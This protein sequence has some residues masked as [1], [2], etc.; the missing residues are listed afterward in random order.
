LPKVPALATT[1]SPAISCPSPRAAHCTPEDDAALDLA[2]ELDAGD[3]ER[4]AD[5]PR[6]LDPLA[7]A[8]GGARAEAGPAAPV[9][10]RVGAPGLHRARRDA[11]SNAEARA[12]LAASRARLVAAADEE[13]RRVVR[14]LHDGAQQHLVHTVITLKLAERELQ[15]RTAGW[16]IW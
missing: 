12:E 1:W 8:C 11:I 10:H 15:V 4:I 7:V 2:D 9:R 14:D 3:R 5:R 16:P 6:R 13:R